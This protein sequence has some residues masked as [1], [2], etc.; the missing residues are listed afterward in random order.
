M[1]TNSVQLYQKV[2][3]RFHGSQGR[4]PLPA[5]VAL[6]R[7]SEFPE[8]SLEPLHMHD[9]AVIALGNLDGV[10]ADHLALDFLFCEENEIDVEKRME[11]KSDAPFKASVQVEFYSTT[12]DVEVVGG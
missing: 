6:D 11:E 5:N 12:A 7:G 8:S 2:P 10:L 1:F 3:V 4:I 9:F